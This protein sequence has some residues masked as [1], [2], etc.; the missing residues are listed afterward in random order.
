MST[1][2]KF[3]PALASEAALLWLARNA[4][5][6]S[7][8]VSGGELDLRDAA[9]AIKTPPRIVELNLLTMVRD[10]EAT[11]RIPEADSDVFRRFADGGFATAT[12]TRKPERKDYRADLEY[13][14]AAAAWAVKAEGAH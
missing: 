11:I 9:F 2:A 12:L 3:D 5:G 4:A 8:V 6:G 13:F 7:A 1:Q 14:K 10:G